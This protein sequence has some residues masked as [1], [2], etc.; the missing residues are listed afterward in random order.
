MKKI[1]ILL[2]AFLLAVPSANAQLSDKQ[3]EKEAKKRA[4]SLRKEGYEVF[5]SSVT[6]E[7]ALFL[8][9]K[10]TLGVD[11][12]DV[13]PGIASSVKSKNVA[14]QWA[15]QNACFQ[16]AQSVNNQLKGRVAADMGADAIN[17]G[18]EKDKF[19]AAYES[20]VQAQI[21][22]VLKHSY[23]IIKDN[24]DGTYEVQAFFIVNEDEA[25]KARMRA[26]ENTLAETEME[27]EFAR[28]V[29]EFVGE[30]F[31]IED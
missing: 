15:R 23:S 22:G 7:M 11:G 26:L 19:Y 16:Y 1:L 25:H 17:K 3:C 21:N 20:A 31:P 2:M 14:T 6:L 9:N 8:H 5:G 24:G 27:Q 28:K 29:S 13:L 30:A 10:K 4:K 18:N 12:V